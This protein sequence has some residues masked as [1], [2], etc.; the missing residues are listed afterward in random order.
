MA[1]FFASNNLAEAALFF[2]QWL[3][4]PLRIAAVAPSSAT[5]GRIM[6]SLVPRDGGTVLE[7][8]A[9]TGAIGAAL[10]DSGIAP[11]RLLM[12]EREPDLAR[13]LRLRFPAV[14]V[15]EADAGE[16][17]SRSLPPLGAVVSTLPI[18]WFDRDVQARI[19]ETCFARLAPGAPFLQLTN[20]PVSPLPHAW[21]GLKSE[22]AAMVLRNLPPSFI[23]RYWR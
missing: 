15:L 18:V 4:A 19:V 21:L 3:K 5:T 13:H 6:A 1:A 8:G 22:R 11:Q 16:M 17:R 23:W 9:G 20:R 10:L 7:L 2:R 12:V 14:T